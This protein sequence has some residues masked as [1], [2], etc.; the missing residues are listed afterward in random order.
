MISRRFALAGLALAGTARAA[1]QGPRSGI[2]LVVGA[3]PGTAADRAARLFAPF[4][5]RALAG[6]PVLVA[7]LPGRAGATAVEA[8]ATA[9]PDGATLGLA[10]ATPLAARML[11]RRVAYSL[12]SF[13]WLGAIAAEGLVLAGPPQGVRS[14][15][16]LLRRAAAA[17]GTITIGSSGQGSTGHLWLAAMA[18]TRVV[19]P[20]HV[21]FPGPGA[22]RAACAAG[23]LAAAVLPAG[24]VA[25]WLRDGRLR[26]LCISFARRSAQL[27]ELPTCREAGMAFDWA[28]LRG[29][30][31][32]AGLPQRRAAKISE[33]LALVLR[34]PD[35]AGLLAAE[36]AQPAWLDAASWGA[37]A[38]AEA[39][40]LEALWQAAPWQPFNAS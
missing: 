34:D 14:L 28:G 21:P 1:P 32:P 24:E 25:P 2:T 29:V 30:I 8:V 4:L 37:A 26:G 38:Q 33:A 40:R 13:T 22:A 35:L 27:P 16:E 19:E 12:E 39:A 36:G 6:A 20:L 18:Q 10:A 9:A 17:P 15:A 11:D 7:N 5:E 3:V 23:Q 31:A